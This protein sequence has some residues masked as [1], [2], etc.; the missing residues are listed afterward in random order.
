MP[1]HDAIDE[2][3]AA[4]ARS[5]V[6]RPS[7]T[8]ER[9]LRGPSPS[10]ARA[11]E[12]LQHL[13]AGLGETGAERL[14]LERTLGAGGMG[15]VHLATQTTLGRKV[16]VKTLRPEHVADDAA[17]LQLLREAWVTGAL[18]HPN[19]VPVHDI[20]LDGK[21]Q[22]VIVLKRIS[23]TA[24]SQLIGDPD[25]VARRFEAR[26]VVEWHLRTLMQVCN[27]VQFAHERGIL[28]RDLKP[29]NVMIGDL[30]EVYVLDWGIAVSL[31]DDGSGRFPL[32]SEAEHLAGTP[33]YMA[34]EML[35]GDRAP[36]SARTDVWLL[37][38]IL[39]ELLS[40]LP[41]RAGATVAEII[42]RVDE[43][44][45]PVEAA[46]AEL[47]AICARALAPDPAARYA[48]ALE[49]RRALNDYLERRGALRLAA[50]AAQALARLEAALVEEGP[51]AEVVERRVRIYRL[52]G[53]CRF[54]FEQ[55]LATVPDLAEARAGMARAVT[56]MIA[57]ELEAGD[58]KAA[59]LLM[60][61]L[62]E[63]APELVARVAEA[64]RKHREDE[65]RRRELER[66][67][68]ENDERIGRRTRTFLALTV[69]VLW[70]VLPFVGWKTGT[71]SHATPSRQLIA[72]G[73]LAGIVIAFAIW[74]RDT[75]T[76][77]M[78]NR[79]ATAGAVGACSAQIV[80]H[81]GSW[82]A[83]VPPVQSAIY[84]LILFATVVGVVAFSHNRWFFVP[85]LAY[86]A[87]FLVVAKW[88]W[89]LPFVLS[90]CNVTLVVVMIAVW[91]PRD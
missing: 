11:V 81:V 62:P 24:W 27:A 20:A 70:I 43:P 23:G 60:A 15:V 48:S 2:T 5:R 85:S 29:D 28:H 30:G 82:L 17:R 65:A 53:E 78:L 68:Q 58:P 42:D 80:L 4:P 37:G 50:Q 64:E 34:P 19:V 35:R 45:A 13:G 39:Y 36:L 32:A 61:S 86:V 57:H 72:T 83:G 74:A 31:V 51:P 67:G 14:V 22:P 8:V 56:A 10:Q 40:G 9:T 12:A 18:E 54:G 89:L 47:R 75:M 69:G 44:I 6:V 16:A 33:L 25:E 88:S 87:G 41:P 3:L 49:L 84:P 38:A 21:G 46:P 26:D 91:R 59:R 76:R 55:A 7:S 90:A 1:S 63:P 73:I 66:I 71:F 52:F 77:T 79:M